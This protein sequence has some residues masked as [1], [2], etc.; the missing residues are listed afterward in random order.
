MYGVVNV[1]AMST[2]N[3]GCSFWLQW[4]ALAMAEAQ[5]LAWAKALS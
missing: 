4:W 3:I 2:V 5:A 1:K